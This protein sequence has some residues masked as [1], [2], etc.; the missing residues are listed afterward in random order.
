MADF[1]D[2]AC[3]QFTEGDVH[4]FDVIFTNPPWGKKLNKVEKDRHAAVLE[5][6][7]SSDTSSLFFFGALRF[8]R[9]GGYLGFLLPEAFFNIATFQ[10]AREKALKYRILC[11]FDFGRPFRTLLTK[12]KG[13]LLR[14]ESPEGGTLIKCIVD[15]K[16]HF[17]KQEYFALNP[18]SI[19]NF[20]ISDAEAG[21]ISHVSRFPHI[22]LAA[23]ARWG[24][25]IVTG[26]NKRF[27]SDTNKPNYVP[28]FRG[29]DVFTD[30]IATPTAFIP[31]DMSQ[32][33]QV[34]PIELYRAKQKLIYRF[35]SSDLVFYCDFDQRLILNSVN[36]LVLNDDFPV[37]G[38]V[39]A[40]YLSSN[41]INWLFKTL[42]QTHKVLRSDLEQ[43]P[44]FV[45]YLSNDQ[46]FSE[47]NLLDYLG[48]ESDQ[49][50]SY[51]I[52]KQNL[53]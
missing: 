22:T 40:R 11:L 51:R 17:L 2:L 30:R 42:F 45:E 5:A 8:I 26:N 33:Q 47:N 43:L 52:K 28:V 53:H 36:M 13:I 32:Y 10:E 12:A 21:V 25:G 35:I 27:I 46:E 16:S 48:I 23:K 1:L 4:H 7:K 50:G 6:G 44:I 49:N 31:D 20:S 24:L 15:D 18:K 3:E 34:A 14:L 41:F 9:A 39:L 37:S 29:S 19:F 38:E